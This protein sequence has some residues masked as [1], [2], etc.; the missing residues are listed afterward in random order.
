M[1]K[2]LLCLA[3]VVATILTSFSIASSYSHGQSEIE[4][5][6]YGRAT[7]LGVEFGYPTS[8]SERKVDSQVDDSDVDYFFELG[9]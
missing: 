9:K 2:K 7:C 1:K 8:I 3:V 4:I 6:N 5:D